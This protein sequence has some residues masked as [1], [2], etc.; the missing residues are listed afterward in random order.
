MQKT[1]QIIHFNHLLYEQ[2]HLSF[3]RTGDAYKYSS[4]QQ[5]YWSLLISIA[6]EV[7][8]KKSHLNLSKMQT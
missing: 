7:K 8:K 5:L 6:L 1:L 4:N 2:N 3:D